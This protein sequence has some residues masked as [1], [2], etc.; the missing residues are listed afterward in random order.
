[1]IAIARKVEV[2]AAPYKNPE[3]RFQIVT[4]KVRR[5]WIRL[6]KKFYC[7]ERRGAST[8]ASG[9]RRRGVIF[10]WPGSIV[11]IVHY[12][13]SFLFF[14]SPYHEI[15]VAEIAVQNFSFVASCMM[16]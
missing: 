4:I 7:H 16:A 1:M 2:H 5:S 11:P 6:D 12:T 3:K 14:V 10:M 13:D 15:V 8:V 9:S